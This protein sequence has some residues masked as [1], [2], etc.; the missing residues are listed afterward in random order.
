VVKRYLAAGTTCKLHFWMT[1]LFEMLERARLGGQRLL[2]NEAAVL[3]AAAVRMAATQNATLRA[4]LLQI[5]DNGVLHLQKFDERAPETE[6]SFLAPELLGHDAPKK[7]EPRVQVFAAG[8]LGYEL[9]TGHVAPPHAPGPELSGALGDIVRMALSQDRRERFQDLV[10]L[11]E[12]IEG[13]QSRPPAEGERNILSALRL[14]LM[15][16]PPEKEALARLIEKVHLLEQQLAMLGPLHAQ[17]DRMEEGIR[18]SN[19]R[20][21][22]SVIVPAFLAGLIGAAA[23]LGAGYAMGIAAKQSAPTPPAPAPAPVPPAPLPTPPAP[24]ASATPDAAVAVQDAPV[25]VEVDAGPPPLA[26]AVPDAG[27]A[28]P[29]PA[30]EKPVEKAPAKA[31]EKV[32]EKKAP[33]ISPAAMSRALALSQ[34]RRGEA[35]L[36]KGH[37]DEA[38][39]SFRSALDSDPGIAAAYRGMGMAYSMQGNDAQALQSYQRYLQLAPGAA[40]VKDIRNSMKELKDRSKVSGEEK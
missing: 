34:I 5:D 7:T 19:E 35:A 18:R 14:R 13:V 38:L 1:N 39:S 4:R 32:A 23:V 21:Q 9:L 27:P 11:H 22:P 8:A 3:F 25:A 15:K 30:V 29:A 26:L 31:P 16:P 10:Q 36:E 40:D 12:A 33:P 24:V 37:A 28:A 6:P 20:K 17:V 2:P